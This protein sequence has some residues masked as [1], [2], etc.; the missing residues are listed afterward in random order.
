[1]TS[2][3]HHL[4]KTEQKNHKVIPDHSIK[5]NQRF[6]QGEFSL[7]LTESQPIAPIVPIQPIPVPIPRPQ[8]VV[9][10]QKVP[11]MRYLDKYD[12]DSYSNSYPNSGSDS[13]SNSNSNSN[14]DSTSQN[15]IPNPRIKMFPSS[16]KLSR[17]FRQNLK[18]TPA[19]NFLHALSK[20]KIP[21]PEL[22]RSG[23][24][25][26]NNHHNHH[27]HHD[28]LIN[29]TQLPNIHFNNTTSVSG[30]S[31]SIYY[32]PGGF[33]MYTPSFFQITNLSPSTTGDT[34]RI[35][36]GFR[37][38]DAVPN[39]TTYAINDYSIG[40]HFFNESIEVQNDTL[41]NGDLE[42]KGD[43][44]LTNDLR[45]EG[46]VEIFNNINIEGSINVNNGANFNNLN[47]CV[48]SFSTFYVTQGAIFNGFLN[49]EDDLNLSGVLNMTNDANID[50]SL[51]VK[52]STILQGTLNVNGS[53]SFDTMYVT[54]YAKINNIEFKENG[55]YSPNANFIIPQYPIENLSPFTSGLDIITQLT[56]KS[57]NYTDNPYN[58]KVGLIA[59]D[60]L[61]VYPSAV[62]NEGLDANQNPEYAVDPS[63][64]IYIVVNA[65]KELNTIVESQAAQI[66]TL[67]NIVN[68]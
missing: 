21:P 18:S 31:N 14:S 10:P 45:V 55:V 35:T 24:R 5:K 52:K 48:G 2:L 54:Q 23:A 6:Y 47:A 15:F 39:Y 51:I 46:C 7:E 53:A 1:V 58:P 63:D 61:S 16:K 65:I 60:L 50:G 29:V 19:H 30:I 33:Q 40:T 41:L 68:G 3:N 49:L 42:V 44:H 43:T 26:H 62:I 8:A 17:D 22:N 27:N 38:N 67:S 28:S 25:M 32:A 57:Y 20:K 66:I 11:Q 34:L 13:N 56:P 36:P 64:F 59:M 37:H 12:S 9:P 4:K